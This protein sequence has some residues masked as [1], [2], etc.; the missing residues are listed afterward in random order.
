MAALRPKGSPAPSSSLSIKG[1]T[2]LRREKTTQTG[3]S[4]VLHSKSMA[5]FS[6]PTF[7]GI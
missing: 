1:L 5:L 7:R 6:F 4:R 2:N 3:L